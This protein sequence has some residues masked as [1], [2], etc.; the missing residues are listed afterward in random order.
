MNQEPTTMTEHHTCEDCANLRIDGRGRSICDIFGEQPCNH[1][2]CA[3]FRLY[4]TRP[5]TPPAEDAAALADA[6][7]D[8]WNQEP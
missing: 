7:Y 3:E 5:P 8:G 1:H 6:Q 2:A 4:Q